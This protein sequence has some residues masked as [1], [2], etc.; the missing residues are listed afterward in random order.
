MFEKM[1]CL[2]YVSLFQNSRLWNTSILLNSVQKFA[3]LGKVTFYCYYYWG[4]FGCE[5]LVYHY[6]LEIFA[7][8]ISLPDELVETSITKAFRICRRLRL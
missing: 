5:L 7:D 2:H 4:E 1:P 6:D 3:E 8:W